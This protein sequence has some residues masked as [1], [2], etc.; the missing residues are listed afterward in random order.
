MCGV[1]V[2]QLQTITGFRL[3]GIVLIFTLVYVFHPILAQTNEKPLFVRA[4]LCFFLQ[5]SYI[6]FEQSKF[7]CAP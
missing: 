7:L 4:F 2:L 1:L 5:I 3:F 6:M